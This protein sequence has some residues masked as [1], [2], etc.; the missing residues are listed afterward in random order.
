MPAIL[1]AEI[2]QAYTILQ[3]EILDERKLKTEGSA[4]FDIT[5]FGKG[6][7]TSKMILSKFTKSY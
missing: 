1:P 3:A 2:M 5:Q 6:L 4:L 7:S